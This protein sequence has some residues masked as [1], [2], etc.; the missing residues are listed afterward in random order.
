MDI[1]RNQLMGGYERQLAVDQV[2]RTC[3]VLLGLDYP[4]G[5]FAWSTTKT[6][7]LAEFTRNILATHGSMPGARDELIEW[8]T[9]KRL[10]HR[11]RWT[12][13][14]YD[15]RLIDLL[16]EWSAENYKL[17]M[18]VTGAFWLRCRIFKLT[19]KAPL[20]KTLE[21][22][23]TNRQLFAFKPNFTEL[24]WNGSVDHVS[25]GN[26]FLTDET[27]GNLYGRVAGE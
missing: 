5:E 2:P 12:I 25:Y 22:T 9:P 23:T 8:A 17:R 18:Q 21:L 1:D 24:Y 27:Y 14:D 10:E 13:R 19:Y 15:Q 16:T 7:F 3:R 4:T 6:Y 11:T 20:S 26:P